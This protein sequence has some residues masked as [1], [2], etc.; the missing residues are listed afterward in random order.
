MRIEEIDKNMAVKS[1]LGLE[2][3]VWFDI[4]KAP[5][6]IFGLYHPTEEKQFKRMPD[7]VASAAN[8][9]V[10]NL[11]LCTAGGRVRF[12]TDSPYVALRAEMEGRPLMGHIARSGQSGFDLYLSRRGST[13]AFSF[14]GGFRPPVP[15][16]DSF[17]SFVPMPEQ[18][19]AF[20]CE[21]NFP[22]YDAVINVYIGLK[23]GHL[24]EPCRPYTHQKPLVYLG[25]SITQGGCVSRP[26]NAFASM[27]S[28]D[29]DCDYVNLGFSGSCH[30]E[31]ALVDYVASFDTPLFI[32]DYDHNASGPAQLRDTHLPLYRRY[33]EAR[34]DTPILFTSKPDWIWSPTDA[35]ARRD[36]ILETITYALA[37]GDKKVYFLDGNSM[38]EGLNRNDCTVDDCHPN[39]LGH[40]RMAKA[41]GSRIQGIL[42]W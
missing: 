2:D 20:D 7:D 18:G 29:F 6:E 22:T 19:G 13:D 17:E 31:P 38:W 15:H 35:A 14:K 36:V 26:G 5:F 32:C 23:K 37:Q 41:F 27:I 3:L 9:G 11:N 39:D 1:T 24:L 21:V 16:F 8:E 33:R 25:S 42:H 28:R 10:A 12:A 34:P 4:R 40:Y 30:G